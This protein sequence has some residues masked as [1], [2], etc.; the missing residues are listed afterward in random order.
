MSGARPGE[1]RGEPLRVAPPERSAGAIA[2]KRL[3][4]GVAFVYVLPRLALY[5]LAAL[6]LGRA[7]AFANASE[8]VGRVPGLRGL[9]LRQAFYRATLARCGR[10]VYFGWLCAVSTPEARIGERA[11]IG[12]R[13]GLGHVSLGADV[14][15]ADGVQV[16]SGGRQHGSGDGRAFR[17]QVQEYRRVSIGDGAWVGAGAIVMADV[18][19]RSVIGAGAVVNRPIEAACTAAGV[20][21]RVVRPSAPAD[22]PSSG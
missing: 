4:Q 15:L 19:E 9:Y 22:S 2:L 12:R 7:R 20:P 11:Y 1:D 3:L 16:L 8:G 17:E 18:G 6:V 14:M 13:C 10:D 5:R 21:A